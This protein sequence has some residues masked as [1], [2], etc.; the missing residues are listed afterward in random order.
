MSNTLLILSLLILAVLGIGWMTSRL[1]REDA[2][3]TR[4]VMRW[5][6]SIALLATLVWLFLKLGRVYDKGSSGSLFADFG[7]VLFLVGAIAL[8]SIFLGILW[9]PQFG[10]WLAHP[11][12]S[13]FDGG[14][15]QLEPQP[16]YSVAQA[17]CKRGRYP[18]AIAEIHRQLTAFP[19]DYTGTL[20]LADIQAAR[21]KDFDG[22]IQ[23]LEQWITD[24]GAQSNRVPAALNQIAE[25]QLEGRQ[26]P[27]SARAALE[28]VLQLFPGTEAAHLASQR[29]AHLASSE[30]LADRVN[31]HRIHIGDF[32]TRVGLM[33]EPLPPPSPEDPATTATHCLRQ[34]EQYP[35]DNETRERLARLYA[36]E[37]NHIALARQEMEWLLAQ[38][39]APDREIVR[40]L[41]LLAHFELHNAG[42]LEA[43]RAA[44][45]RIVVRFPKSAAAEQAR[46]RIALLALEL[47]GKQK[48]QTFRLG[49]SENRNAPPGADVSV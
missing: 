45:Q 30:T 44:L 20:L 48:S 37:L 12:V 7:T 43:A 42:N 2:D 47:R 19:G 13:L 36:E 28:R 14:N 10:S 6:G 35:D 31:P 18:E 41:N 32:P 34:L 24:W 16:L 33:L 15:Q 26:D 22:A 17:H 5:L 4:S 27:D 29:I 1:Q 21:Q 25:W 39:K 23:I 9:A 8:C 40:W 49:S 38:P 11:I 3:R 46:Q